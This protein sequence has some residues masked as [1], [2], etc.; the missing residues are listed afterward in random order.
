VVDG[1]ALATEMVDA[2]I[3][4]KTAH[5]TLSTDGKPLGEGDYEFANPLKVSMKVSQQGMNMEVVQVGGIT[6]IKGIP[7]TSK[8]WFK[9]DP[10]GTDPFSKAMSSVADLS[11]SNDPRALV[12][13]MEGVKGRDVGTEQVGGVSTKHYAFE[14][15]LSAYGKVL[16]P[17]VLK[18]MEGMVKGPIAMGYWVDDDN[19]PRKLST[20]MVL[21]G[22]KSTTEITYTGQARE[23]RCAASRTGGLA[24]RHVALSLPATDAAL[25][26]RRAAA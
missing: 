16:S 15:P 1:Q 4:S 25:A 12:S 14:V 8:P 23:H 10:Q 26:P 24:S 5:T 13:M 11:K 19:L 9:L 3:T 7:G 18:L 21:S 6:Y 22:K 17:Q 2:M 20:V